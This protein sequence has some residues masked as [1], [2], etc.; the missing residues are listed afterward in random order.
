MRIL[1]DAFLMEKAIYELVYE[2]NN[3]PDWLI[4]PLQGIAQ[5][6]GM[7]ESVSAH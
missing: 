3:R 5:I 2:L 1:L 7:E 6:L 4:A